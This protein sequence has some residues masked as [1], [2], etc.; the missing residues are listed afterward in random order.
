MGGN[1]QARSS[2]SSSMSVLVI[3]LTPDTRTHKKKNLNTIYDPF[4]R[5]TALDIF[6][7]EYFRRKCLGVVIHP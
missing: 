1:E 3:N 7:I 4:L 6:S 5:N 2:H